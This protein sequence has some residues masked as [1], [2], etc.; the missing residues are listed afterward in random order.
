MGLYTAIHSYKTLFGNPSPEMRVFYGMVAA[1]RLREWWPE[2]QHFQ[3]KLQTAHR[4]GLVDVSREKFCAVGRH[5]L[6]IAWDAEP[7]Q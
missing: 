2:D 4:M 7:A 6:K 1:W 3:E 5:M